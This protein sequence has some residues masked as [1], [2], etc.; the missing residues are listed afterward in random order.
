MNKDRFEG[1]T[2]ANLDTYT[3]ES[4]Q[5]RVEW[6]TLFSGPN[7][8]Y[9]D[10]VILNEK[11]KTRWGPVPSKEMAHALIQERRQTFDKIIRE[12]IPAIYLA[13]SK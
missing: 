12:T 10:E 2:V 11:N 13:K 5:F 7:E 1:A 9:V 3:G 4:M 8:Y 6:S